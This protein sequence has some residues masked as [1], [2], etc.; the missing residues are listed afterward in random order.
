MSF[1]KPRTMET[2]IFTISVPR[3]NEIRFGGDSWVQQKKIR[4]EIA[5]KL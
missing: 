2:S 1:R 4:E 5:M 3:S